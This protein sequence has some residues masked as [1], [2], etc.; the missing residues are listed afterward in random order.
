MIDKMWSD[1]TIQEYWKGS[2]DPN[3]IFS[4]LS[5]LDC[6]SLTVSMCVCMSVSVCVSVS[7]PLCV[8]VCVCVSVCL[9][10]CVCLCYMKL[11]V[12]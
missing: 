10:V 7:V 5:A 9:C 1:L 8:C 4:A 2:C 3:L 11:L 6:D 12:N